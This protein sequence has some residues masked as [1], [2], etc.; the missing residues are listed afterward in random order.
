MLQILD[1]FRK[2]KGAQPIFS[3]AVDVMLRICCYVFVIPLEVF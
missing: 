3:V 1:L 2:A